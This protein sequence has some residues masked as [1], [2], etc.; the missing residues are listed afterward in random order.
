MREGFALGFSFVEIRPDQLPAWRQKQPLALVAAFFALGIVAQQMFELNPASGDQTLVRPCLLLFA[1]GSLCWAIISWNTLSPPWPILPLVMSAGTLLAA[2]REIANEGDFSGSLSHPRGLALRLPQHVALRGIIRSDPA[3]RVT[4]EKNSVSRGT[5]ED[6]S[7]LVAADFEMEVSAVRFL[8]AWESAQ[9]KVMVRLRGNAAKTLEF[10]REIEVNGVL[11]EPDRARN[12]GIFD[13]AAYLRR[14]GVRHVLR[15]SGDDSIRIL[16]SAKGWGWIFSARRK[17]SERLTL[18]IEKDDPAVRIIRGMLLGYRE[19][20]PPDVN[21][22]FRRTGTLHVFA[23]SGSHITLIA[24]A[25]LMI[26]RLVRVPPSWACAVVLPILVFYVVATG[27]RASAI[28]ALIMAGVVII[29]GSLQ[30]PS[31]LLNSLAVSALIILVWA[32]FQLFDPGFQLSFVVVTALILLSPSIQRWLMKWIEPDPYIPRICLPR[33]RL[34]LLTP[35]RWVA[36]GMAVCLAAWVGSFGLNLYYFNLVS[37]CAIVANLFIVPLASASVALGVTSLMLGSLGDQV[38]IT[39]NTTHAL[40]IHTMVAISE[41]L[42]GVSNSFFYAPQ[43]H[44]G[45]IVAGYGWLTAMTLLWLRKKRRRALGLGFAGLGIVSGFYLADWMKDEVRVDVLDVGG[46]QSVLVT[47][48]RFER[49][50]LDAGNAGQGRM[51]VEP[52]LRSRGVNSLDLVILSH[53]DAAHYGGMNQ[54]FGRVPFRRVLV[55]DVDFRSR[56]YRRLLADLEEAGVRIERWHGGGKKRTK[57]G[58]L[59][60]EDGLKGGKSGLLALRSGNI[61]ILWPPSPE[62]GLPWESNRADDRALVFELETKFGCCLFAADAGKN[63]ESLIFAPTNGPYALLVQGLHAQEDSLTS[64]E[65]ISPEVMV[66]NSGEY[67]PTA[68][69]SPEEQA[70]LKSSQSRVYRTDQSGGVIIRLNNQ[71]IQHQSFFETLS[72]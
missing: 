6:A 68:Y 69:P 28:R 5:G 46:G 47:G 24:L 62:R 55:A 44:V 41:R 65:T 8:T 37:F 51:I 30:R 54:L 27:L 9:G 52:F 33:W 1:A 36:A 12:F 31:T 49:V 4:D 66:L 16:G 45:W 35:C 42:A 39:L 11:S 53:G 26:L 7:P 32:P 3:L 25:F 34:K 60:I 50:L 59:K 14:M 72:P 40:L 20:I 2:S 22:T 23:I 21:D 17:L 38:A 57:D 58:E 29:G 61:S 10:G 18:G 56:G 15:A 67:P 19:D 70:R 43:P 63:I 48:P 13:Y 71:G 64:L